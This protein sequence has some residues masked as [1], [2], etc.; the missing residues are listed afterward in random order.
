M[1]ESM[2]AGSHEYP[3]NEDK[4][5]TKELRNQF[6]NST[7]FLGLLMSTMVCGWLLAFSLIFVILSVLMLAKLYITLWQLRVF[8]LFLILTKLII[9]VLRS[10]VIDKVLNEDGYVTWPITFSCVYVILM[11][12][13]F[14]IG[15]LASVFRF[16]LLAPAL[17]Y[18][19]NTLDDTMV[20]EFMVSS[21]PGYYCLLCLTYTSYESMNPICRAFVTSLNKTAH[22]LYGP[23]FKTAEEV[24]NW[25]DDET[26]R[27]TSSE[28]A[29]EPA[30]EE[31]IKRAHRRRVMRNK[32]WLAILMEQ[33]P[34]LQPHRR[35]SGLRRLATTG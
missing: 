25:D 11:I 30:S 9:I 32:L 29:V 12:L 31:V 21:D 5:L 35:H 33:N 16:I 24:R 20:P 3:G 27:R 1:F 22:R 13:N 34:S 14:A 18:R 7:L 8:L 23:S 19:F 26:S 17:L 28:S 15:L 6:G 10:V 2:Q 4:M